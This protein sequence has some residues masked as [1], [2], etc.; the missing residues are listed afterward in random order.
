MVK[1][2]ETELD[3]LRLLALL[4]VISVHCSGMGTDVVPMSDSGK[5][6][7]TFFDS[8][9]TWQVPIYVM[10][11]GRFFLDPQR[12]VTLKKLCKAMGRIVTA[13]VVWNVVYQ[14]Y[15][16]LTGVYSGLNW[17]GMLFQAILG[18]YHFWF[19][20]MIVGLYAITPFLR[21]IA[22]EKR[23]ME[24]FIILFVLFETLQSYGTSL[25]VI[26]GLLS[27]VLGSMG[28]HF[29][30]GFSGYFVL[31]YYLYRYGVP[32][33]LEFPLYAAAGILLIGVA[34]L[35]VRRAAVEGING[36]WYTGYRKPNTIIVASALF[37]FFTTRV[38]KHS[39]SERTSKFIARL[40]E[41]SF[42]V[43]LIHALILDLM[44]DIGLSPLMITPVLM[45]PVLVLATFVLCCAIVAAIRKIPVVGKK[46]T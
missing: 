1:K 7:L 45:Q 29:A 28:F 17:K 27:E 24:Y 36:E 41:F 34:L 4:A 18:P 11:S 46:I 44:G 32:K 21:K 23:L 14:G 43:Y 8:I 3:I 13:F 10:I 6:I 25:P 37:T 33:K 39:F 35:T 2:R 30:L 31:G 22:A 20:F 5:R 12:Q 40:S 42:G 15:Y 9:V 38:S 26:G 19:L 16:L